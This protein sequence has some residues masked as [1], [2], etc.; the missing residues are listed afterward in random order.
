MILAGL[1][2][3]SFNGKITT[4]SDT[5]LS[6]SKEAVELC[7]LMFGIVGLWSGLMNIALSLGITTQL[8]K[9]LT[10]FL[11]FLFPNLKNQKA[12]EYISTNIVANILGLGWAATPSGLKAMEELQKDNPDKNTAT[13][14]MCSFLILNISSLQLIPIN[15]IAYRSQYGSVN[16]SKILIPG[17][18]ATL[19]STIVAVIYI[20]WK[21]RK[22]R[23]HFLQILSFLYSYL[24]LFY[25]EP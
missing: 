24:H 21:D 11:T 4:L 1:I 20:K 23:L 2:V 5:I 9:L 16:P 10:P 22:R 6:S 19:G 17:L 13:N 18:I 15:I 3:G 8:Q 7:I 14:E 25:M 12:K